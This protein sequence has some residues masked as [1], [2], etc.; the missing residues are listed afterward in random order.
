MFLPDLQIMTAALKA[1]TRAIVI[2]SPGNPSG[3]TL[4][5][6]L[7]Q[8]ISQLCRKH[9]LYVIMDEAYREYTIQSPLPTNSQIPL[10]D[11]IIKLYTMSKAYAISGW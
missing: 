2:T 8:D 10:Q 4:P 1:N 6:D 7:L 9:S 11:D 3:I 5:P